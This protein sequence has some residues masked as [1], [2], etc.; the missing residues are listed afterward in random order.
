MFVDLR[1][2]NK[3]MALISG[4]KNAE[5][6]PRSSR[7]YPISV[8]KADLRYLEPLIDPTSILIAHDD[9]WKA[10]RRRFGPGFAPQHLA[11]LLSF[12]SIE[13]AP[14]LKLWT[15]IRGLQRNFP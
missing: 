5:K 13:P 6:T 7:L 15:A 11:T 8:L 12:I 3:P 10:L 1:P 9:P 14:L 4:H 2:V